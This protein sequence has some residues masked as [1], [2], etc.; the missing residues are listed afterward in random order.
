MRKRSYKRCIDLIINYHTLCFKIQ[1][2]Y[3][4]IKTISFFTIIVP[5]LGSMT[6]IMKNKG[7]S[8]L[9]SLCKPKHCHPDVVLI[10]KF[11]AM[12][13]FFFSEH[14]NG[15]IRKI[16]FID[17]KITH[18]FSVIDATLK[19]MTREFIRDSDDHGLFT[20]VNVR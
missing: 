13:V 10:W 3:S 18:A 9:T 6:R 5:L 11:G 19:F 1:R 12:R 20:A 16:V 14:N 4:F 8:R 17:K 7:V 15:R 2:T